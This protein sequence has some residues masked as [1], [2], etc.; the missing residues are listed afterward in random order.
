[1][2]A[3]R[4]KLLAGSV[5]DSPTA[6]SAGTRKQVNVIGIASKAQS[7]MQVWIHTPLVCHEP[8]KTS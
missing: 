1:M 5:H 8:N 7:K 6:Q 4:P 3:A 2:E